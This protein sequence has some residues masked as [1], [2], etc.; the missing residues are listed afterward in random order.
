MKIHISTMAGRVHIFAVEVTTERVHEQRKFKS[1]VATS[2]KK[3][4]V[5]KAFADGAYDNGDCYDE[6]DKRGIEPGI[7]MR[8][9]AVPKF[10]GHRLLRAKCMKE[11]DKLGG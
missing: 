2:C 11:R 3:R 5:I 7:R 4:H 10:R 9:N 1:I 6:Q 8:M